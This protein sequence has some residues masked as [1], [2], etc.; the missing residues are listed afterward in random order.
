MIRPAVPDEAETLT[1][2]TW[3]S[4][5]Y[6][7]YDEVFM[8]K[9]RPVM[10]ITPEMIRDNLYYVLETDSEIVGFYS[11]EKPADGEIVLENLFIEPDAIGAGY[12]KQLLQHALQTARDL[13]YHTVTLEAD[14]N[15]ESFYLKMGAERTGERES[16]IQTGRMLPLLRFKLV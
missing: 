3:R 10:A 12:G 1:H 9:A 6:W 11:L 14:P 15:A 8:A 7:G 16:N 4:K 13:G 5:A 2:L